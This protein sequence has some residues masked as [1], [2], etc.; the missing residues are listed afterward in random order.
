MSIFLFICI[1]AQA[2]WLAVTRFQLIEYCDSQNNAIE[3]LN[4]VQAE[5]QLMIQKLIK[6][7]S[8]SV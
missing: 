7:T 8:E 2:I 5:N 1:V 3:E 4:K 6:M